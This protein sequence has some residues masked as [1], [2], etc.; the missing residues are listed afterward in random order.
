MAPRSA[1]PSDPT[2][3]LSAEFDRAVRSLD[4][5]SF[6][7]VIDGATR[8][9]LPVREIGRSDGFGGLRVIKQPS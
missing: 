9:P 3:V 2:K 8:E 4:Q 6:D 7:A 5:C 1:P